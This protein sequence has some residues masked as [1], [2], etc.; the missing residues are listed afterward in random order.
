MSE[1]SK[2]NVGESHPLFSL[3]REMCTCA[4]CTFRVCICLFIRRPC[5]CFF[6][7]LLIYGI[8]RASCLIRFRSV[9]LSFARAFQAVIP[10]TMRNSSLALT[11]YPPSFSLCNMARYSAAARPMIRRGRDALR[12][13]PG[14]D[15]RAFSRIL[16]A[17]LLNYVDAASAKTLRFPSRYRST[18]QKRN[19]ISLA[20]RTRAE[21]VTR[22]A[23]ARVAHATSRVQSDSAG[24]SSDGCR[25]R[26]EITDGIIRVDA[27]D[28]KG[29]GGGGGGGG[30]PINSSDASS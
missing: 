29:G 9:S 8:F 18:R 1:R 14:G 21:H 27:C 13:P 28:G 5:V 20:T 16:H 19:S 26:K 22:D 25:R 24:Y 10:N 4:P 12:R 15:L 7:F 17:P 2:R 23:R 11:R 6:L 30:S 3:S